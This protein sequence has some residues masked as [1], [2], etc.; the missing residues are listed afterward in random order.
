MGHPPLLSY[1]PIQRPALPY[2]C[3]TPQFLH[4]IPVPDKKR[5]TSVPL[6]E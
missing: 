1:L 3:N 4:F 5:K 6:L 2:P